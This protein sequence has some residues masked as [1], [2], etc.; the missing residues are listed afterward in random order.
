[1]SSTIHGWQKGSLREEEIMLM[2]GD[3]CG[4]SEIDF[5]H[6]MARYI[7]K[8]KNFGKVCE[9]SNKVVDQKLSHLSKVFRFQ[10]WY[11]VTK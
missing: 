2:G 1:M 7:L 3:F 6:S 10:E 4:N 5:F 9:G 11:N 8:T